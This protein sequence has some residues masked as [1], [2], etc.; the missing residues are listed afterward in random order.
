VADVG[1]SGACRNRCELDVASLDDVLERSKTA[2]Q[3]ASALYAK[4]GT[5]IILLGII[6]LVLGILFELL[7]GDALGKGFGGAFLVV[8]AIF[9]I[10][11]FNYRQAARKFRAK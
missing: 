10:W 1:K 7:A 8:A 11:G 2:Y 6:F 5:S 4:S 9:I 3:K